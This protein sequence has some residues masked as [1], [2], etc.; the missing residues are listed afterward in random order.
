ME[1]NWFIFSPLL[2]SPPSGKKKERKK[3]KGSAHAFDHSPC[4]LLFFPYF[5]LSL[6][7]SLFSN[8]A[9]PHSSGFFC[10]FYIP[11]LPRWW[12]QAALGSVEGGGRVRPSVCSRWVTRGVLWNCGKKRTEHERRTTFESE[13]FCFYFKLLFQLL[14]E[15]NQLLRFNLWVFFL[16]KIVL[17]NRES[18]NFR[19]RVTDGRI[20]RRTYSAF[21]IFCIPG[22][23]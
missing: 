14:K 21:F 5:S 12:R 16:V 8:P 9:F 3:K 17:I 18:D 2:P 22:R 7:R 4:L 23:S 15:S 13:S 6:L 19:K 10:P 20:Y 11:V 1:Q